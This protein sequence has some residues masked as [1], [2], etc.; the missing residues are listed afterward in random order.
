MKGGIPELV[1]Y[2]VLD[3]SHKLAAVPP[4]HA[5]APNG[6]GAKGNGTE[7]GLAGA[8]GEHG[9]GSGMI[10]VVAAG[11]VV[12]NGVVAGECGVNVEGAG[13]SGKQ[14]NGCVELQCLVLA[15]AGGVVATVDLGPVGGIESKAV[16][17][18]CVSVVVV[19]GNPDGEIAKGAAD[20]DGANDEAFNGQD[21]SGVDGKENATEGVVLVV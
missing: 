8:N 12:D 19:V 7:V 17:V 11:I 9:G 18:V 13:L 2:A 6:G 5:P 16:F 15:K 21:G 14:D 1:E 10:V 20:R 4:G 3:L